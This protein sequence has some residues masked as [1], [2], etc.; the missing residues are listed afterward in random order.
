MGQVRQRQ[1]RGGGE[2]RLG[3][4]GLACCLHAIRA[5]QRACWPRVGPQRGAA[6]PH[7]AG[8]ARQ[9]RLEAAHSLQT[10]GL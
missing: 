7:H 4:A 10:L 3:A 6:P 9:L 1:E 8:V 2:S 5:A